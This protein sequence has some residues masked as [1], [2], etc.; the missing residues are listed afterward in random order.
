MFEHYEQQ[1]LQ[2]VGTMAT[3]PRSKF[4]KDLSLMKTAA[5]DEAYRVANMTPNKRLQ[6]QICIS[7]AET[8]A[9][10]WSLADTVRVTNQLE[11]EIYGITSTEQ[12]R[13]KTAFSIRVIEFEAWWETIG[14]QALWKSIEQR[15]TNF[16][17]PKMHLVSHISESI[18]Q[19]GSGVNFA[20]DIC[21]QLHIA[22]MK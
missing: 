21:K 22:N 20:T 19:M 2:E 15:V 9:T 10:T 7:D 13:F 6:F 4:A 12:K 8:V 11:R 17:H 18:R 5:E 1:I 16:G 3:G 14:I